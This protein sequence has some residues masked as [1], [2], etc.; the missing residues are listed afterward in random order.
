ML[1]HNPHLLYTVL[2]P[3]IVD[4]RSLSMHTTAA[5]SISGNGWYRLSVTP[6]ILRSRRWC[7]RCS[8][9]YV[10]GSDGE[11]FNWRS[12][13]FGYERVQVLPLLLMHVHPD[14]TGELTRVKFTTAWLFPRQKLSLLG[15][16]PLLALHLTGIW[17]L[18]RITIDIELIDNLFTLHALEQHRRIGFRI[19][20]VK[21]LDVLLSFLLLQLLALLLLIFLLVLLHAFSQ[22]T[23]E[24][25]IIIG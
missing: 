6:L 7:P 8:L 18:A 12:F 13:M 25:I 24:I 9:C 3:D 1:F 16:R 14:R 20:V 11:I 22:I 19:R 21:V 5:I 4:T 2:L 15:R 10:C 23:I 17:L